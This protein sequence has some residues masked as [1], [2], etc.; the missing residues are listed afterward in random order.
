M[1][2]RRSI[3]ALVIASLL[4]APL[5]AYG[6]EAEDKA[7]ARDLAKEGIAAEEAGD[8]ATAIDRLEHAEALFHAP[9]HLQHLA[10]CYVKQG[11]LVEATEAY[12]KLTMENLP[13]NAP[14]VFKDAVDEANV[15]L[16]KLEP[17]LA[18]LKITPKETYAGLTVTLDGRPYPA[19][20]LGISRVANPGKHVVHGVAEGRKPLDVAVDLAEGG[21]ASIDLQ[22]EPVTTPTTSEAPHAPFPWKSVGT[23]TMIVG[24]VLVVGGV[25]TGLMAKSKFDSLQSDCPNKRCPAGFDLGG[26]QDSINTLSTTTNVLLVGGG[27][28]V[29]AGAAAYFLSPG[30]SAESAAISVDFAPMVG[31]GHVSL[32]GSF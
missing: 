16:P 28:L 5:S 8:C 17:R 11:R 23:A 29:L 7:T 24:G 9:I 30:R 10:H 2:P 27:I 15:E 13:P 21:S 25:V 14:D 32:S 1:K 6:G 22:L 4:A 3:A 18:H 31:G 26:K 12:R 19:A 20:A